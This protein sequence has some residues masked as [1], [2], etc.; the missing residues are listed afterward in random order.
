VDLGHRSCHECRELAVIRRAR[1]RSAAVPGSG[2]RSSGG[3]P[4]SWWAVTGWS[5]RRRS[6][7]PRVQLVVPADDERDDRGACPQCEIRDSWAQPADLAERGRRSDLGIE[8]EHA[9]GIHDLPS[10]GH[11]LLEAARPASGPDRD[12][13]ADSGECEPAQ[14]GTVDRRSVADEVETRLDGEQQREDEWIDPGSVRHARRDPRA[15]RAAVRGLRQVFGAFEDE[16]EPKQPSPHPARAQEEP[17]LPRGARRGPAEEAAGR[18]RRHVAAEP[19]IG[20][21]G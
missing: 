9:T 5:T 3:R 17:V 2:S 15:G 6:C 8:R 13:P 19:A 21:G 7:L 18:G 4:P 10:C 11:M 20:H 14:A 12:D 1:S 16:P